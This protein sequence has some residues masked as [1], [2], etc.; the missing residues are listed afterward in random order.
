MFAQGLSE[1]AFRKGCYKCQICLNEQKSNLKKNLYFPN[2]EFFYLVIWLGSRNMNVS[3][4]FASA[5]MPGTDSRPFL[6]ISN[7]L[8]VALFLLSV[9]PIVS[10]SLPVPRMSPI[11]HVT[12]QQATTG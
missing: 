8:V 3:E 2:L 12:T 11:L 9:T 1:Y 6:S 7:G 10:F 4:D 5:A